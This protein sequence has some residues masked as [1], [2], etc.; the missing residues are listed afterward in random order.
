[1]GCLYQHMPCQHFYFKRLK[2]PASHYCLVCLLVSK[3]LGTTQGVILRVGSRWMGLWGRGLFKWQDGMT[4]AA[5]FFATS[6]I[7]FWLIFHSSAC[8][9]KSSKGCPSAG[10]LC[11]CVGG[12]RPGTFW[13]A[14]ALPLQVRG[15]VQDPAVQIENCLAISCEEGKGSWDRQTVAASP[16][17]CSAEHRATAGSSS[18]KERE[19]LSAELE[20]WAN[21]RE[22]HF[23]AQR[24]A[25]A[26]PG[27]T[28]MCF[29]FL[30]P[31]S[32]K[33]LQTGMHPKYF[34]GFGS[35]FA[36]S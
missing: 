17:S 35:R 18:I 27:A 13:P 10:A 31:W 26:G 23:T 29:S 33:T 30:C 15:E 24:N 19:I 20:D 11:F 28:D 22:G 32:S 9:S 16:G 25:L 2:S 7:P 21:T 36:A 4:S 5:H 34:G 8:S 12:G 3:G 6:L 14:L 1:M